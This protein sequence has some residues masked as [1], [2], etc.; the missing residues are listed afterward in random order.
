MRIDREAWLAEGITE[1][2]IGG[3]AAST[4]QVTSSSSG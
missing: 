2:Q 4:R 1:H 3:L